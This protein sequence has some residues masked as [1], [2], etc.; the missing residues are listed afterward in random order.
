MKLSFDKSELLKSLNIAMKAVSSN[1]TMPLLKCILIDASA[2]EIRMISNDTELAI[3]TIAQ[4]TILE[5]G[6]VA[7]EAKIFFEIIR[8]LPAD[9]VDIEVN[10]RYIA[11]ITCGKS[12][13]QI[14]GQAAD[15]F[16]YPPVIETDHSV[17]ISQFT[18]KEMIRKTIFSLNLA[19]NNKL[20]T[21]EL[22]EIRNNIL[23]IISLD[24]HRIAVRRLQL[25]KNYEYT[26][27]VVPGKSLNEVC[28][29][30]SDN[31]EDPVTISFSENHIF[32]TINDTV[33]SSRLIEGD[34]FH[35]DNML[36]SDHQTKVTVNKKEFYNSLER[37]SLL[38][39]ESENK[40]IVFNI[41]DG[42]MDLDARSAMGSMN[43][44]VEIQKEGEDIRIGFNPRFLMDA[45]RVIDDEEITIYLTN[46]R[47]PGF[48]R[49]E[50]ESYIYL[51]LPVNI[52]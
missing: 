3:E 7:L 52:L 27:V 14:P 40:P 29:I 9:I 48:I 43:E 41:T 2:N 26:K 35:V 33:V 19:E 51:I 16:P 5:R 25:G 44:S 37:A 6:I 34:Y 23:R 30:L 39:K 36:S 45:L 49:D 13:F 1:T 31:L 21:G 15:E 22:F 18:F 47:A 42:H 32:F 10:D 12:V 11:T 24:G 38:I 28:K 17:S 8:K 50:E 46:R 20:M 4:G